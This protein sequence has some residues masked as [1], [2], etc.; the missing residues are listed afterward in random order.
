[1]PGSKAG[2]F[3]RHRTFAEDEAPRQAT[4]RRPS[5]DRGGGRQRPH[6]FNGTFR[7]AESY[8]PDVVKF[9]LWCILLVLCWPLALA[10]LVLYPIVWLLLLP[11]RIVGIAVD[12]VLLMIWT[13][14]SL[15]FRILRGV[16]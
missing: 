12:G 14:I 9:L 1:M 4:A 6:K 2:L 16:V 3:G 13:L 10:A 15:P 11:F 7:R 5:D 8:L